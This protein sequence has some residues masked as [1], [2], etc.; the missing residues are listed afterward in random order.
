MK[1]NKVL[2]KAEYIQLDSN[3]NATEDDLLA[4]QDEDQVFKDN[5]EP[6]SDDEQSQN[7]DEFDPNSYFK[8]ANDVGSR[9]MNCTLDENIENDHDYH[10]I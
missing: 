3:R 9:F 5:R 1:S 10:N 2:H 7:S 8:S 4:K 6:G